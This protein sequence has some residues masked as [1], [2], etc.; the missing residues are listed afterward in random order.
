[1]IEPKWK[2]IYNIYQKLW[3]AGLIDGYTWGLKVFQEL[4]LKDPEKRAL[5]F[6]KHV[7]VP[8]N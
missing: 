5:R 6:A 2:Q 8:T 3:E 1:M 7:G 4:Q